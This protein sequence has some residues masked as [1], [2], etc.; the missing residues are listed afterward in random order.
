M[1]TTKQKNWSFKLPEEDTAAYA[2]VT[3]RLKAD[4]RLTQDI[5]MDLIATHLNDCPL[6]F[7]KLASLD[8]FNFYHDINGISRYIDRT[9]LALTRCFSPRCVK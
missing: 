5:E 4:G 3:A 6:N 8:D 2:K 1:S 9:E 7:E